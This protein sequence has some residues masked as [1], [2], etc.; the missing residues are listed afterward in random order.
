MKRQQLSRSAANVRKNAITTA[1]IVSDVAGGWFWLRLHALW[2]D[3]ARD[4]L[5]EAMTRSRARGFRDACRWEEA[6]RSNDER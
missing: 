3:W 2:Q 6:I 5:R 1:T 4:G